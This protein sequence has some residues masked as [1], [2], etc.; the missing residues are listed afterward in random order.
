MTELERKKFEI[1]LNMATIWIEIAE[2]REA[3][4]PLERRHLELSREY[5]AIDL[6]LAEIDGRM[7]KVKVGETKPTKVNT[8]NFT[9]EEII[10]LARVLGQKIQFAVE[11]EVKDILNKIE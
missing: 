8:V 10:E 7:K 5:S 11:D 9:K 3:L 6:E 1:K 4:Q 2:L